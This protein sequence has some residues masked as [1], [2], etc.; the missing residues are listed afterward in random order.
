[1]SKENKVFK[2]KM[3]ILLPSF[4]YTVCFFPPHSQQTT[5]SFL[6]AFSPK[7]AAFLPTS[8]VLFW[9]LKIPLTI[10]KISFLK[11]QSKHIIFHIQTITTALNTPVKFEF[12][13]RILVTTLT[14]ERP[15]CLL[16]TFILKSAAFRTA[17]VVRAHLYTAASLW[18]PFILNHS[19]NP[20]MEN[21]LQ[22]TS[23]NKSLSFPFNFR[24]INVTH[25]D[26]KA[27]WTWNHS[28][29]TQ[30]EFNPIVANSDLLLHLD[31]GFKSSWPKN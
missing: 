29:K 17:L 25:P 22:E 11:L 26:L 15:S 20:K 1:M 2:V 19:T 30:I 13:K 6:D 12:Q 16:S 24:Q 10:F 18:K 21:H 14:T 31:V 5:L 27:L 4:T 3:H 9:Y 23:P 8:P 28:L 7:A